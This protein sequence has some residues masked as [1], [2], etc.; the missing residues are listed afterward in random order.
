MAVLDKA[1]LLAALP[2]NT[3]GQISPADVRSIVD[4][5]FGVFGTLEMVT[6]SGDTQSGIG[7]SPVLLDMVGWTT[8]LSKDIT[9]QD[10]GVNDFTVTVSGDYEIEFDLSF[11]GTAA[12]VFTFEIYVNG[13]VVATIGAQHD[14]AG[15]AGFVSCSAKGRQTLA[16]DDTV[17]IRVNVDSGSKSVTITHGYFGVRRIG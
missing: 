9:V 1:A 6:A 4:S 17:E 10:S 14:N 2:D 5:M 12:T 15:G 8:G 11:T 16:V 3:S 13:S 7:T